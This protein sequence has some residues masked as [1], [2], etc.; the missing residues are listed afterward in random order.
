MKKI[1]GIFFL[2]WLLMTCSVRAQES[3]TPLVG[4]FYL[5]VDD[6]MS[7]F[8]NGKKIH[9]GD[10]GVSETKEVVLFP[11]DRLVVDVDNKGGPYGL[12]MIFV[13]KDRKT[14]INF[15]IDSFRLLPID[16]VPMASTSIGKP[17]V[18]FKHFWR[19]FGPIALHYGLKIHVLGPLP[20]GLEHVARHPGYLSPRVEPMNADI[21]TKDYFVC[22]IMRNNFN[23]MELSRAAR[24]INRD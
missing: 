12:K 14:I 23:F 21:E 18:K 24:C 20:S 6:D 7:L 5:E 13:S 15:G 16:S 4:K 2:L 1:P 11:G 19:M 17:I 3:G 22:E 8:L 10:Y 9:H